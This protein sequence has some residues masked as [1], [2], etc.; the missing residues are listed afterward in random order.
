MNPLKYALLSALIMA[1]GC[2]EVDCD[3]EIL[4]TESSPDS[5]LTAV[6]F[7]RECGT[8][9][10]FNCQV[11]ITEKGVNFPE[12]G[13]VQ[14]FFCMNEASIAEVEWTSTNAIEIK[15]PKGSKVIRQ[16]DV[17][18]STTVTYVPTN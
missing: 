1:S 8:T 12:H 17:A 18:G 5:R 16:L 2:D 13:Q 7:R 10:G 15:Y 14:N 9:T 11:A 4:K 3:N 6:I